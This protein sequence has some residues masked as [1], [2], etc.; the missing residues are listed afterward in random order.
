MGILYFV[1]DKKGVHVMT[2][3]LSTLANIFRMTP[4]LVRRIETETRTLDGMCEC[5]FSKRKNDSGGFDW[6][7]SFGWERIC[8]RRLPEEIPS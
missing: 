4:E 1:T 6:R 3:P 5:L 2:A 7:D 8:I